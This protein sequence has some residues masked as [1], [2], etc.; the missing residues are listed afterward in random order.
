MNTRRMEIGFFFVL[1]AIALVVS[2]NLFAP[3]VNLVVLAGTL[4]FIFYPAYKDILKFVRF[5]SL[6]ALITVIAVILIVFL[7]LGFFATKIFSEATSLY[8]LLAPN[9]GV[10]IGSTINNF[11][12]SNLSGLHLPQV[13]M[14]LGTLM[15][16]ILDWF[17]QNLGSLFSNVTQILLGIFL[18]LLG[19]FYFLKD[20]EN[21]KKWFFSLTSLEP[22][23][24]NLIVREVEAMASSVI[25][26]TLV[27][28]LIQSIVAGV[29]F[30]IFNL[31]SPAFWGSLV[32]IASFIP[33]VGGWIVLAPAIIYLFLV[34]QVASA[35]GLAI[36]SVVII[37]FVYNILQPQL[38]GRGNRVHPYV[39]LLSVLGGLALF[40]PM[41]LLMGP[42]MIAFL[43]SLFKI[44]P[45]L[46]LKRN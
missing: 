39:I 46:I 43:L 45:D 26:G 15:R 42:L 6:A 9:G 33:L 19:L 31:P 35:I 12:Q 41:G 29:G 25:K 23:Y 18:I 21:L 28:V 5:Q 38:M 13:T 11:T 3:Y 30:T 20:G 2:W 34:G 8:T 37:T 27:I 1:L 16:Q 14:D 32:G 40:G 36:W 22:K 24:E 44:Y 7:P 10:D 4:A 17:V